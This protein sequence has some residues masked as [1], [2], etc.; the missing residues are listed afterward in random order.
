[1]RNILI[2][3]D[4]KLTC[5]VL[6]KYLSK[7]NFN[8]DSVNLGTETEKKLSST[9]FDLIIVDFN[10]PDTSGIELIKKIKSRNPEQALVMITGHSHVKTAVEAIK[11]GAF[12]YIVKPIIPEELLNTVNAAIK[13]TSQAAKEAEYQHSLKKF[14]SFKD[15]NLKSIDEQINLVAPT[16]MTVIV[17]GE[18][19]TGKEYLSR[20][21]HL[22]SKRRQQPFVAVDC[23]ALQRNIAASELF[24]HEKG[25]FTGALT[26]KTG[27]FELA[28]G[29]TLFLDE[30]G[31]LPYE[32]QV[33][34]LRAIQERKIRRVGGVKDIIVD[35]RLIV[36]T[37]DDLRHS[38][39]KGNFRE[40]LF[41]RLNEFSLSIPPLRERKSELI[42]FAY[43]FLDMANSELK[44]NVGQIS[45]EAK[46]IL[47]RHQWYGNLRELKNIMKRAT[48]FCKN[49]TIEI[50]DLPDDIKY[51]D[52]RETLSIENGSTDLE[53]ARQSTECN[54]IVNTLIKNNFNKSK[55][56]LDLN[57]DRTT[58]YSKI[59]LFNIEVDKLDG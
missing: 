14:I 54:L 11:L 59:K 15:A 34:M 55:T 42:D 47:I 3:D 19:G 16:N 58:L 30:I 10:L 36:A 26:S 50:T 7:N 40:D 43:H 45:E 53:Q 46:L 17:N 41:H 22:R 6:S 39:D 27:S 48:L 9:S 23:G 4:D 33:M 37:N 28:R 57:I 13:Q 44:K 38:I 32:I 25:A 12:D 31:N 49:Y 8:V 1:M 18:T 52:L 21:I 2:I 56:A 35:V 20:T 5:Q 24:G 29:G 51:P